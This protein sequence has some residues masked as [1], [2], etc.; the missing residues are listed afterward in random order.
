MNAERVRYLDS[1]QGS[2]LSFAVTIKR[3]G[4]VNMPDSN[5]GGYP[6][7]STELLL[8]SDE[9]ALAR[10]AASV[11]AALTSHGF[12]VLVSDCAQPVAERALEK[13][14]Q[15]GALPDTTKMLQHRSVQ[16]GEAHGG[17]LRLRDEPVYM[18][19]MAETERSTEQAK[20]QFGCSVQLESTLWPEEHV[21]A[22]FST[23][24]R[25]CAVWFD[26]VSRGVLG[27]FERVLGEKRGFLPYSPGYLTLSMYPGQPEAADSFES[28]EAGLGEHSD[29]DVFTMLTQRVRGLQIKTRTGAW[30]TVPSLSGNQLLVLPGDWME[31]WSNGQIPAVRHRVLDVHDDRTSIA[32]FQN[33]SKM[34]IGP[35]RQFVNEQQPVAYPTVQSDI[36]YVGGQ[37]GVARWQTHVQ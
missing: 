24:V 15:F 37:S 1:I 17:W 35:L 14:S 33:V 36:D 8:A 6:E 20:Q 21:A 22:G 31:L 4:S 25:A 2:S 19:H 23:Q 32:F 16:R 30:S 13:W 29:A 28:A 9:A 7:I 5:I 10:C 11:E 27:A 34:A 12:F 18:S 3:D 26:K